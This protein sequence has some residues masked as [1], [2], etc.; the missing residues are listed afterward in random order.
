MG[1]KR[2]VEIYAEPDA[3][4][5]EGYRFWMKE[6]G[7]DTTMLVFNKDTDNMKKS[8]KYSVDFILKNKGPKKDDL[9]FSKDVNTVLWAKNVNDITDPCPMS[10]CYMHGVFYVDPSVPIE[11]NKLTV[12]NVD[13]SVQLFKFGLNFLRPGQFDEPKTDYAYYDPVGSNQNGG[14]NDSIC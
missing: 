6:N 14:E 5:K 13:P 4:K 2:T 10:A 11:D 8:A 12:V 7:S 1:N 9:R 3:Q